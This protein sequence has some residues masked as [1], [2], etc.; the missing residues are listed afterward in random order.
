M[1][2]G[3][4]PLRYQKFWV[5]LGG[6]LVVA[7]IV[8]SL[9]PLELPSEISLSDKIQHAIAYGVLTSWFLLIFHGRRAWLKVVVCALLLG[10]LI[11]LAQSFTDFRFAEWLDMA[12][13][14]FGVVFGSVVS[15]TPFRFM[16]AKFERLMAVCF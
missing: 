13:N 15:V 9:Y 6:F 4:Y 16:L 5:T 10:A 3:H 14:T 7:I 11:E 2:D 1:V 12:A 8:G